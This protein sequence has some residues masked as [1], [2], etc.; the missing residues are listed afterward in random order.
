MTLWTSIRLSY[1][2]I[3]FAE[4]PRSYNDATFKQCKGKEF[5]GGR[6]PQ[7]IW[8]G[9]VPRSVCALHCVMDRSCNTY[10]YKPALTDKCRTFKLDVTSCSS[11]ELKPA[12][13]PKPVTVHRMSKPVTVHRMSSRRERKKR[14]TRN[15][16][17][18]PQSTRL[19]RR[20]RYTR[21]GWHE[22]CNYKLNASGYPESKHHIVYR[23]V[24]GKLCRRLIFGEEKKAVDLTPAVW[25]KMSK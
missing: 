22:Y 21:H 3:F 15:I 25:I 13:A 2:F 6:I 24:S 5:T 7:L 4:I 17:R 1:I 12:K 9:D 10:E 16:D 8:R 18:I 20:R 23:S 11:K 19:I 14:W